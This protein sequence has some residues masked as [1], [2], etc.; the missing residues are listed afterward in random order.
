MNIT[1]ACI[2]FSLLVYKE[3]YRGT[4]IKSD[5]MKQ[6]KIFIK[7]FPQMV[8]TL[9][10]FHWISWIHTTPI[11]AEEKDTSDMLFFCRHFFIFDS[12]GNTLSLKIKCKQR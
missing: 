3:M 4:S 7:Y 10:R 6:I 8:F 11:Y 1:P 5:D 2:L 12:F 9:R